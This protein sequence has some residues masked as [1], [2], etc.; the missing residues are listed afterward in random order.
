MTNVE[1]I[2]KVEVGRGDQ[3][4]AEDDVPGVRPVLELRARAKENLAN[5]SLPGRYLHRFRYTDPA[6][7]LPGGS[8]LSAVLQEWS[9]LPDEV[10]LPAKAGGQGILVGNLTEVASHVPAQRLEDLKRALEG[11]LADPLWSAAL[12]VCQEAIA[13]YIPRR[14]RQDVPIVL[15]IANRVP[16]ENSSS[17]VVLWGDEGARAKVV[18]E[19]DVTSSY[20]LGLVVAMAGPATDLEFTTLSHVD[21]QEKSTTLGIWE[22]GESAR[23]RLATAGWSEGTSKADVWAE[24]TGPGASL[25]YATAALARGSGLADHRVEVRHLATEQ[26]SRL[27][28]RGIG[29]NRANAV[30]TGLLDVATVASGADSYQDA[31]GLVLDRS[32]RVHL[33]PEL[34]IHNR[35]VQAGHG[36][37]VGPIDEEQLFYMATRGLSRLEAKALLV[38]GFL[39]GSAPNGMLEGDLVSRWVA[40]MV[41]AA[42]EG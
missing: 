16:V 11:H 28:Y 9:A 42:V 26:R 4:R 37:A 2:S 29:R 27:W 40:W 3:H 19:Q 39:L 22:V 31:R 23:V 33:I 8:L 12:A 24:L 38:E 21:H 18:L 34:E 41:K 32:A 15:R 35:D 1:P 13:V 5:I 17:F 10:E 6:A 25:E 7:L 20:H 14:V 36:A 30:F